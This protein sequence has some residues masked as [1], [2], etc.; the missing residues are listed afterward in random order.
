MYPIR[1]PTQREPP[2]LTDAITFCLQKR[3]PLNITP[4]SPENPIL[5]VASTPPICLPWRPQFGEQML[6]MEL[7]EHG[8]D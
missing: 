1:L 7:G 4:G 3:L 8:L 5:K 6:T 2:I